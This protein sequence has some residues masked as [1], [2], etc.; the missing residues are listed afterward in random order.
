MPKDAKYIL[1]LY[2]ALQ[3]YREAAK[4]TIIIAREEQVAGNRVCQSK[5]VVQT[6]PSAVY[7]FLMQDTSTMYFMNLKAHMG[8]DPLKNLAFI[9]T[10]RNSF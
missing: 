9:T 3:Q 8:L 1:R 10:T 4:T 7:N 5:F 6:D 2:M